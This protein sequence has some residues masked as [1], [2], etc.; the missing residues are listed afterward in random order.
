MKQ[1]LI[2]LA[3][4]FSI[5]HNCVAQYT[6]SIIEYYD[7]RWE[8]VDHKKKPYVFY[9]RARQTT[10]G[11]W[12][13]QDYYRHADV[14]QMEGM[15]LDDSMTIEDGDFFYY[16]YNGAVAQ[17]GRFHKG[18]KV[19]LWRR[20][21]VDGTLLDSTRFKSTGFPYHKSFHWDET[22]RLMAYG[23]Y[24]MAGTGEGFHIEYYEDSTISS[25]TRYAKGH[26]KDSIWTYY[27]RNGKP[28]LTA[29][30]DSGRLINFECYDES[31]IGTKNCDTALRIPEP[32]YNVNKFLGENI[33]MPREALEAE[34]YGQYSVVVGIVVDLDGTITNVRIV[35]GSYA[36]FNAEALRVVKQ[37]PKWQP[38]RRQNRYIRAYYTLPINFRIE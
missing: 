7:Y 15:F 9:R 30:Y 37:L 28:S 23:E 33:R 29:T 16:H 3:L 24:D 11:T 14:L 1:I 22:G 13:V 32:G 10:E 12:H 21:G 4:L 38:A 5:D 31:G 8:K 35:Q 25:Y 27:H 26:L 17:T 34:L 2:I 20:Y 19:G 36:E 18:V 6:D